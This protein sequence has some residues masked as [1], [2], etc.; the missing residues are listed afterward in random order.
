MY[1]WAKIGEGIVIGI[2]GGTGCYGILEKQRE[3]IVFS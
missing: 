2:G 3:R 1:N